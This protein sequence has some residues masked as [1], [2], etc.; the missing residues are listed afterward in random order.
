[1]LYL[2]IE[3]DEKDT[4]NETTDTVNEDPNEHDDDRN[5]YTVF[6]HDS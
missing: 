6:K 5:S 2:D 4:V 3:P 1:V